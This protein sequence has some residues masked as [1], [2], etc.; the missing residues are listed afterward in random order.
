MTENKYEKLVHEFVPQVT[1][2]GDWCYS[3]QAY[4]RGD[5]DI[6]GANYNVGFQIFQAPVYLEREPHFHREEEF[7]IFLGANMPN[8]FDF[9]AEI[10]FY[11]GE[12]INNMEKYVL[13]KPTIIRIPPCMWHCPLDFKKVNKPIF[14]QAALMHGKFGSIKARE[15][16]NGKEYV[17]VGDGVRDCIFDAQK[18]CNYCGTCFKHM[19]EAEKKQ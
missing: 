6:P 2:W 4:F 12:D 9:D 8:V 11:I 13:T 16:K 5:V 10:D 18:Q 15:G 19:N 3:P 17:Y 7:L 14:F 1:N